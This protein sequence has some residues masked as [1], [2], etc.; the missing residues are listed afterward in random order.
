[1]TAARYGD[2]VL[3]SQAAPS[4]LSAASELPRR[5]AWRGG[6]VTSTVSQTRPL[7]MSWRVGMA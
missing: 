1:M 3:V 6:G 4:V 7:S 2:R 5:R